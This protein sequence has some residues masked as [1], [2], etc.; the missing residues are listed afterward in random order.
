[1]SNLFDDFGIDLES[2]TCTFHG[3]PVGEKKAIS[4]GD[5]ITDIEFLKNYE[6]ISMRAR[7]SDFFQ[8]LSTAYL[9]KCYEISQKKGKFS[10]ICVRCFKSINNHQKLVEEQ[11]SHLLYGKDCYGTI[12]RRQSNLAYSWENG[13]P[14]F[15]TQQELQ[16]FECT[17]CSRKFPARAGNVPHCGENPRCCFCCTYNTLK[18]KG[19]RCPFELKFGIPYGKGP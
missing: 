3:V 16:T 14:V 2:T 5:E 6:R 4:C 15:Q 18:Y 17:S 10:Y 9:N 11:H 19:I 1:M 13:V 7:Q 8:N 12:H